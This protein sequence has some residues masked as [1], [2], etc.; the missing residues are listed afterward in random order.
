M[1]SLKSRVLCVNNSILNKISNTPNKIPSFK[2]WSRSALI[3]SDFVGL[4]LRVHNGKDFVP[5][6]ISS[7]MIGYRLGEF[8]STRAKYEFKKKKKKK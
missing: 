8:V 2:T 4:K 7:E 3:C 6:I 5:L 1:N